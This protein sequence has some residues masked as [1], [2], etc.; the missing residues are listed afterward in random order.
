MADTKVSLLTNLNAPVLTDYS[1]AVLASGPTERQITFDRLGG[2]M[3]PLFTTGRLTL[4]TGDAAPIADQSLKGTLYFTSQMNDGTVTGNHFQIVIY[5]GT[6]LR[7]YDSAEINAAVVLSAGLAKDV[8]IYDN[9]GTLALE[10][11]A[12]W[13]NDTTR[14][15]A[16]AAQ[17]G[18][19]VKS[20]TP[21]RR[22]VGT[23]YGAG[24]NQT[25]DT[26]LL[27]YVSNAYNTVQRALNTAFIS[28]SHTGTGASTWAEWGLNP[29]R[30]NYVSARAQAPYVGLFT[31]IVGTTSQTGYISANIDRVD[32]TN[33]VFFPGMG[34]A[35]S[36]AIGAGGIFPA[37][38]AGRHYIACI[39][40][41]TTASVLTFVDYQ[42][43][44]AIQA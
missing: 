29:V 15:D 26:A 2:L 5:D 8:F 40:Y 21:T 1:Y 43:T 33:K 22:H 14:A 9:S 38:A 6:R 10:Y 4:L 36:I 7:L 16:L 39:E 44:A 34:G 37:F 42:M 24:T 35:Y 32:G 17:S 3:N 30:L 13:T 41:S 20:G 18:L 12:A 31:E 11:S 28:Q 25:S 23:I 27:R 19:I